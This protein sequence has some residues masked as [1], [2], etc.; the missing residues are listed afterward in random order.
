MTHEALLHELQ[1]KTFRP[2]YLLQGDEAFFID[3]ISDFIEQ[4]ALP[5]ADRAF[6][7]SILYGKDTDP[8][9]IMSLAYRYPMMAAHQVIIVKEAQNLKDINRL[10]T[11]VEKHMPTTILVLAHKQ[12]NLAAN[13]KLYKA[14]DAKGVVM[15][16]T[17]LPDSQLGTWIQ[18]YVKARQYKIENDAAALMAEHLGNELATVVNELDKLMILVPQTQAINT[19][20]IADNVGISKEYNLFELQKA[21]AK[22]QITRAF[23][24]ADYFARNPKDAP[25]VV[26]IGSLYRF[27][28]RLYIFH[29]YQ[30]KSD[31][32]AAQAMGMKNTY[33]LNEYKDASKH[34]H[35]QHTKRILYLLYLYDLRSKGVDSNTDP[36]E[37][38]KELTFRILRLN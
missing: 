5:E 2:V 29:H 30:Q 9:T 6:N 10:H 20:H 28:S 14:I 23:Q 17:K 32:E 22:R 21:L 8:D 4:N 31:Q 35:L 36:S 19:Q 26:I 27:F 34:Y 7:Q 25:L 12:K 13:T 38:L 1:K 24:I 11:Y 37:L 15:V 33:F 18:Q 16:A 3:Q